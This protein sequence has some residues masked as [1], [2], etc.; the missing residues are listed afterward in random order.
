ML[1][2]WDLLLHEMRTICSFFS[3]ALL[4]VGAFGVSSFVGTPPPSILLKIFK[5][6]D[7]GLDLGCFCACVRACGEVVVWWLGKV[8]FVK[9]GG[10][11]LEAVI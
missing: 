8:G 10:F 7:L 4:S 9:L 6:E 5:I 1:F 2:G 3:I 11:V